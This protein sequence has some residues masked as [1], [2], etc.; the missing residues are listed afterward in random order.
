MS[1]GTKTIGITIGMLVVIVILWLWGC[2]T[3]CGRREPACAAAGQAAVER[4]S[5][6]PIDAIAYDAPPFAEG[7]LAYKVCDRSSGESW[8]LVRVDG[9]WLVLPLGSDGP[10]DVG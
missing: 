6:C 3:S 4:A 8:W 10:V 9:E 7:S 1:D 5:G 2:L